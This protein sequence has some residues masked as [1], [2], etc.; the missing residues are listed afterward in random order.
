M[1]RI[2]SK[3]KAFLRNKWKAKLFVFLSLVLFSLFVSIALAPQI[4]IKELQ[5]LVNTDSV[6]IERFDSV[7]YYPEM[8]RLVGEKAYKE[9]LLK[10]AEND[11]IQL[12]IN[13][14]DSTVDL[15]MKGVMIHQTIIKEFRKDKFFGKITLIQ[16]N[17]LFSQP[18]F[19]NSS[20]ATIV[21]EPVVVRHAPKDTLEAAMNAWQPDTLLQNPAFVALSVEYNIQIILEQDMNNTFY[22]KW[23]KFKFYKYLSLRKAIVALEN[24]ICF[25]RQEYQPTI[26]I[27]MPVDDLRAIYRTLPS[28]TFIVIKM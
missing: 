22:D 10:L 23:R 2:I 26:R 15:S 17:K 7:Y 21:K 16:E 25:E 5:K 6:F 3:S 1:K 13:L 4:K 9:A 28:N 19:V 14:T 8:S 12:V 11:S 24:F 18:L 20:Y 27:K